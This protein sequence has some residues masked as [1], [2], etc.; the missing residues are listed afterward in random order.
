MPSPDD[1]TAATP[2]VERKDDAR[3]ARRD[4][5]LWPLAAFCG[6]FFFLSLG[7][8]WPLADTDLTLPEATRR[9]TATDA[10]LAAGLADD[11][12]AVARQAT[13]SRLTVDEAALDWVE[14]AFGTAGAQ[15]LVRAGATLVVYDVQLKRA[16]DPDRRA[17]TMHPDGRLLGVGATVQDDAP[18]ARLGED[19]ARVLA[20]AALGGLLRVRASADTTD[21]ATA[22]RLAAGDA[23]WG[24]V[25]TARWEATPWR[26][27]GASARARP[28]RTDHVFT[29]ERTLAAAPEL[30]ERATAVVSGDRVTWTTRALVVPAAGERARR[31]REAP[32][33][34]LQTLGFALVVAAAIGALAV[35]LRRLRDG[36]VRLGRA[37]YWAAIVFACVLATNALMPYDLLA[38]WDPLWPRWIASTVALV[39][40][41]QGTAWMFVVLF[42]LIAAGDAL[43]RAA[44]AGR[45]ETLWRLG[46]GKLAD[47][48]V[49]L[50]TARGFAVGLI[51]GA[52][53]AG[54]VW[55]LGRLP[56]S[57]TAVQPRGFFYYGL[58]ATLPSLATLLFFTNVALLEELGY[59][60]FGGS[61]LL[62]AT[63]RRWIAIWLPALVY[64]LTH[65]ALDFLPPAEPFWGRALVMTLVGA[66]WGWAFLRWD[67][68]TVVISHLTADLFI[69]NWPRLASGHEDVR[70]AAFAT[71]AAPLLPALVAGV[72]ALA[73]RARGL[74]AAADAARPLP[75]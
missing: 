68:L 73:R 71:V 28:R 53:M 10:L 29:F 27:I 32:G 49:G 38:A 19:S 65:T 67:A 6:A 43:D 58:N 41:S 31:A 50:A 8:L 60:L 33:Q 62:A 75:D 61:W 55:V 4:W 35:F 17:V 5:W 30:R 46:R 9:A 13:A 64:G 24:D 74:P 39:M 37:A 59:R 12:D 3:P 69:F 1:V 14:R 44:G 42:A 72:A 23:R 7:R 11:P 52:V 70:W 51:C 18:G 20:R 21:D 56:G 54:T 36:Q 66:V 57:F 2:A 15:A 40:R 26:E 34:A 25:L 22:P 47:P 16:G 63:R 45:G 48:A